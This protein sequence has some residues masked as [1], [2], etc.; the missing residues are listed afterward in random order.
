M[1]LITGTVRLPPANLAD[2]RPIMQRM[3]TASRAEAGC[4]KYS[5]ADDLFDPG[6]IHISELWADRAA[7]DRHFATDHIAQWR[8]AWPELGIGERN[9]VLYEVGEGTRL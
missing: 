1:V 5:Y 2:A 7:L 9:L 6:L 8:A 4:V 3:V